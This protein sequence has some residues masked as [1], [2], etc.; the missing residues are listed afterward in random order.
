[1]REPLGEIPLNTQCSLYGHLQG[2][3]KKKRK[4]RKEG[5]ER[6]GEKETN[7]T[8]PELE[9]L[10]FF[11]NAPLENSG[12]FNYSKMPAETSLCLWISNA[13]L[14][15]A[16]QES[17]TYC[18]ISFSKTQTWLFSK[19]FYKRQGRQTARRP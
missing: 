5:S 7:S 2:K 18:F 15:R 13:T 17:D 10:S 3:V 9:D 12:I 19:D 11:R 6:E 4:G 16:P 8:I 1:M 14:G